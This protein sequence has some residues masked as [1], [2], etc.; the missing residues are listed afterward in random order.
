MPSLEP[1]PV[2]EPSRN[3]VRKRRPKRLIASLSKFSIEDSAGLNSVANN[4]LPLHS[5]KLESN[6]VHLWGFNLE[7]Q[8]PDILRLLL[9]DDEIQRA[10][11][12]HFAKDRNHF[13]AARGLLRKLLAAYLDVSPAGLE[14]LYGEKGKPYLAA[15]YTSINFN[16]AHSHKMAIYAFSRGRELGVDLEYIRVDL[17]GDKIAERFFSRREIDTLRAVPLELRKL[18]FFNCWT[19]KEAYIKALGEGLS[20]PLD[21]FDVSLAPGEPAVL[22]NNYKD[23]A[24]VSRWTMQ[25]VSLPDGYVAALVVEGHDW[26]L[27][28]FGFDQLQELG[29]VSA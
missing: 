4:K 22:L 24:E 14:I 20:M 1:E 15:S 17:S 16:L 11:R 2:S 3:F 8:S 21:E 7:Q 5:H 19:R 29:D 28:S 23:E 9:S 27:K 25:S 18:A 10:G 13:I 26:S 12:F 6:E